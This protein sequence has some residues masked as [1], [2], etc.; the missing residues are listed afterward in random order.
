MIMHMTRRGFF[1]MAGAGTVALAIPGCAPL[2]GAANM[3]GLIGQVKVVP[4]QR[5]AL[6]SISDRENRLG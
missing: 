4:G 3:Y 2:K 1:A 6:S 5:D